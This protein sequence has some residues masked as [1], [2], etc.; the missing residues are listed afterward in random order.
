MLILPQ[1]ATDCHRNGGHLGARRGPKGG[2]QPHRGLSPS[3]HHSFPIL[4]AY[5]SGSVQSSLIGRMIMVTQLHVELALGKGEM[6]GGDS[7]VILF[8]Y[9]FHK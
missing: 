5:V 8:I 3:F 4:S 1:T 7:S 9:F 2:P 6:N